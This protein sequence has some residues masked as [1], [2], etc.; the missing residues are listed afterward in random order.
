MPPIP[1]VTKP[2]YE[3]LETLVSELTVTNLQL[4]DLLKQHELTQN[5]LIENN[6]QLRDKITQLTIANQNQVLMIKQL[7]LFGP[8]SPTNPYY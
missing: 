8:A 2:T 7:A 1:A 6:N 5:T 3:Q 4:S